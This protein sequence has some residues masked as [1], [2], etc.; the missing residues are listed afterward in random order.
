M[1]PSDGQVIEMN[2]QIIRHKMSTLKSRINNVYDDHSIAYSEEIISIFDRYNKL[3]V[4]LFALN[5]ELFSD[6]IER[7]AGVD[8]DSSWVSSESIA[9]LRVD[10]DEIEKGLTIYDDSKVEEEREADSRYWSL[11]TKPANSTDWLKNTVPAVFALLKRLGQAQYFAEM[12][13]EPCGYCN[14]PGGV[15]EW[16]VNQIL[17]EELPHLSYPPTVGVNADQLFDHIEFFYR[18]VSK[19]VAFSSCWDSQECPQKFSAASGRIDFTKE[20]NT[21][22]IRFGA[23]YRLSQGQVITAGSKIIEDTFNEPLLTDDEELNILI[24]R[25]VEAFRDRKDRR[26]EAAE[27]C[28]KAFEHLKHKYG[29]D[30]KAEALI[31]M[32]GENDE[33]FSKLNDF[34]SALTKLGHGA[35][36]HSKPGAPSTN[37]PLLAEYLFLQYYTAIQF[38]LKR[39]NEKAGSDDIF[40]ID[41]E[42]LKTVPTLR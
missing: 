32:L 3:R 23:L 21:I 24:R 37:D 4:E 33:Q 19:P 12:L 38:A 26:I 28:C 40:S 41:L 10:L 2:T 20:I 27:V 36:R 18:R 14:L 7:K 13:G 22:F 34:W 6:L 11:R 31:R 1:V 5:S 35:V 25:A 39:I 9:L 42:Q 29:K 17:N 30:A 15:S 8:E 16:K